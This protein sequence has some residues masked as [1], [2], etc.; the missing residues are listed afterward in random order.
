MVSKGFLLHPCMSMKPANQKPESN[1][2]M[3][4]IRLLLFV[5]TETY[6]RCPPH[7]CSQVT[8]TTMLHCSL[9]AIAAFTDDGFEAMQGWRDWGVTAAHQAVPDEQSEHKHSTAIAMLLNDRQR[10]YIK[11]EVHT[12][13]TTANDAAQILR[14]LAAGCV[15][16][17]RYFQTP[18][19]SPNSS[20]QTGHRAQRRRSCALLPAPQPTHSV[21]PLRLPLSF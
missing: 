17:I 4:W 15:V 21:N 12:E 6:L 14:S 11:R 1:Q 20:A 3:H 2:L 10:M 7:L 18:G 16:P 19:P 9:L 13:W 8:S 5:H